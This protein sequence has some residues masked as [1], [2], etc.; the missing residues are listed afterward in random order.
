MGTIQRRYPLRALDSTLWRFPRRKTPRLLGPCSRRDGR[1]TCLVGFLI[2]FI[3]GIRRFEKGQQEEHLLLLLFTNLPPYPPPRLPIYCL[4]TLVW[5]SRWEFLSVW[6]AAINPRGTRL[7]SLGSHLPSLCPLA[8]Q[9]PGA[10]C[11]RQFLLLENL[12][13]HWG[14]N[15]VGPQDTPA[16]LYFRCAT[17]VPPTSPSPGRTSAHAS[18]SLF[19]HRA[20]VFP[21]SS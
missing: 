15:R 17:R 12:I 5:G 10:V 14:A 4:A 11:P 20:R 21:H 19:G 8:R 6:R 2:G 9:L 18:P 7:H 13:H 1:R 16:P 3:I